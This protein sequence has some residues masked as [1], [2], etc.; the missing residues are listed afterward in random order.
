MGRAPGISPQTLCHN[1]PKQQMVTRGRMRQETDQQGP[2]VSTAAGKVQGSTKNSVHTFRSIPYGASTAGANR[3]RPPHNTC[4]PQVFRNLEV[5]A[6]L[7]GT[8]AA[9]QTLSGV[10]SSAWV[11][12]ARSGNPNN[13]KL[14]AWQPYDAATR[15]TMMFNTTCAVAN[16]P[17]REDRLALL[18][19][20]PVRA[21]TR[22]P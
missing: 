10:M 6:E 20:P 9:A 1:F 7:T 2:T 4:I 17:L 14:P 18:A 11:Q 3:Y 19:H 22:S 16:D 15:A 5:T 12:F 8:G 13:A 21:G